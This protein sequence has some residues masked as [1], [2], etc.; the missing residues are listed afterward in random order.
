ML[1]D[2]L[3]GTGQI[4]KTEHLVLIL[5]YIKQRQMFFTH[6]VDVVNSSEKV[7]NR[8]VSVTAKLIISD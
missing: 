1:E 2:F 3:S 8:M 5:K 6:A 4:S 7:L